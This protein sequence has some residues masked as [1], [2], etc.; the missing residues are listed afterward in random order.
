MNKTVF[1]L[2]ITTFILLTLTNACQSSKQAVVEEAPEYFFEVKSTEDMNIHIKHFK[3]EECQ[4]GVSP[5]V[6]SQL[7][8]SLL[9]NYK[10][11]ETFVKHHFKTDIQNGVCDNT[12]EVKDEK[13][14]KIFF[15]CG[16]HMQ[17]VR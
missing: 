2:S 17:T 1:F 8:P 13:S 10:S 11:D 12:V 5:W 9:K 3:T 6:Y 16:G 14:G 15:R 7:K 4:Q